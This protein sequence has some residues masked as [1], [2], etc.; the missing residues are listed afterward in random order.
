MALEKEEGRAL[1]RIRPSSNLVENSVIPQYRRV[2]SLPYHSSKPSLDTK[3]FHFL[4]NLILKEEFQIMTLR[5][6][7][8]LKGD[9][10]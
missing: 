6:W 9:N 8:K 3:V 4:I 1:D 5:L 10:S 7:M 2:S